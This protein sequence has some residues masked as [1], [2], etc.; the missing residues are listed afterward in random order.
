MKILI[1]ILISRT[2]KITI[3]CSL[4]AKNE[5]RT[6]IFE[7]FH[8]GTVSEIDFYLVRTYPSAILPPNRPNTRFKWKSLLRVYT[9]RWQ[10]ISSVSAKEPP[11]ICLTAL[12][13]CLFLAPLIFRKGEATNAKQYPE[14]I[15]RFSGFYSKTIFVVADAWMDVCTRVTWFTLKKY[16]S[17]PNL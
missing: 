2:W 7:V 10:E 15:H 17:K 4:E 8:L 3:H 11:F 12:N 1:V 9:S 14:K 5:L 6:T 16:K 13:L